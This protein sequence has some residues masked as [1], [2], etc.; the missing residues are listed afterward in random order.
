VFHSLNEVRQCGSI[1]PNFPFLSTAWRSY[2]SEEEGGFVVKDRR[3]FDESG[4]RKESEK[5]EAQSGASSGE[6]K[7]VEGATNADGENQ[8]FVMKESSEGGATEGSTPPID[9]SS[10][11]LSLATQAM[12]QL[13]EMPPPPGVEIPKNREAAKHTIDVIEML[14]EKTRGNLSEAERKITEEILHNLRIGYVRSK[15]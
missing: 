9:Y 2:M 14:E 6:A 10:F 7:P 12:V 5:V 15:Q 8:D 13:G 11:I 1:V 3:R 4:E